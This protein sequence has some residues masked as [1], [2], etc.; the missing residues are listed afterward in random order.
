M[1]DKCPY[2]VNIIEDRCIV[3]S[4]RCEENESYK[5]CLIYWKQVHKETKEEN[6]KLKQEIA[7]LKK[8]NYKYDIEMAKKGC[9]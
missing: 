8:E 7:G 4:S 6:A 5:H 1:S 3:S 9:V 2:M